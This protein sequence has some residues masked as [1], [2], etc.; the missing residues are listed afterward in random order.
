MLRTFTFLNRA[1]VD[2]SSQ[3]CSSSMVCVGLTI[4]KHPS[5]VRADIPYVASS[6]S[7]SSLL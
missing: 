2:N 4:L 3:H 5:R 6:V 7:S 1:E